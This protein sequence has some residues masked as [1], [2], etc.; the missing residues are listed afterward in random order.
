MS[1]SKLNV[2]TNASLFL[3]EVGSK[4]QLLTYLLNITIL[5]LLWV[6]ELLFCCFL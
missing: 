5:L 1:M 4:N 6:R 3:P 2:L